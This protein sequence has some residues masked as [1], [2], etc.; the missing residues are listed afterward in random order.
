GTWTGA[1]LGTDAN[2]SGWGYDPRNDDALL[3]D[4]TAGTVKRLARNGAPG[5][6]A[7]APLFS[8]TGAFSDLATLTPNAGIVAYAPNVDFWSDY[9]TKRRWFSI[10]N[11]VDT[12]GF[13]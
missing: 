7:P 2:I 9:A 12:V 8:G 3:C 10:K 6:T 1:R 11:L 13:S 4:L 5:G